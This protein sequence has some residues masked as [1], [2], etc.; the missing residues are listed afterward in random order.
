MITGSQ[1]IVFGMAVACLMSCLALPARAVVF[2]G[3]GLNELM[4]A[5]GFG[6]PAEYGK[7]AVYRSRTATVVFEAG[8]RRVVVNGLSVFLN[9]SVVKGAGN[10]VISPVDA[11][12]TIGALLLPSRALRKA[13]AAVV[14]LDPGHGGADPGASN[15]SAREE[16]RFTLDIA[17]RVRL[18]L[19]QSQVNVMM[20]RDR[21]N[22]MTLDERCWRSDRFGGDLFVSIHLN[23]S[24]DHATS[25]VETYIM[26]APGY[27]T[28]AEAERHLV[29]SGRGGNCPGNQYDGANAVL[30][31][32]L[33]K[34]LIAHTGA[35][36]R[37]IRRARFFVIRNAHCPAALVECG[38]LSNNQEVSRINDAAYR[39]RIAEGISRGILTYLSRVRTQ[40]LPPV[41]NI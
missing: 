18:K 40:H 38:F 31:Q 28:T 19:R 37:G 35:L 13:E 12:D 30:A 34:G 14:V 11:V 21:D 5:Y 26:P 6:A 29:M 9:Q 1:K 15:G 41:K 20:T 27:P 4:G 22:S 24:R 2:R 16:K 23:S 36:D 3:L 25:G 33:H 10:W 39:D 17:K 7:S 32:Y 8:S